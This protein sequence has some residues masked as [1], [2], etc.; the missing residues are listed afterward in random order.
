MNKLPVAL[1]HDLQTQLTQQYGDDDEGG[2]DE[3]DED[4]EDEKA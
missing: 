4:G 3:E 1:D 2:E